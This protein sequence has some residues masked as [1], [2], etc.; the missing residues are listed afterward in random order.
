VTKTV[1]GCRNL[2]L[3]SRG[4]RAGTPEKIAM[5]FTGHK[6]RSVFDRYNIVSEDDLEAAVDRTLEY[7]AEKR[8]EAPRVTPI[9]RGR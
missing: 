9:A 8:R 7:V 2:R 5:V 3:E 4:A 1:L 6:T